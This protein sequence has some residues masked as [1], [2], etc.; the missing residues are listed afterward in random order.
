MY[1]LFAYDRYYPQGA[2]YDFV[3]KYPTFRKCVEEIMTS[4]Y[5]FANIYDVE[6]D[7]WFMFKNSD[8][9]NVRRFKMLEDEDWIQVNENLLNEPLLQEYL[10]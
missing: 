8:T 10:N 2:A 7:D 1:L 9:S 6:N 3:C 4:S 5:T